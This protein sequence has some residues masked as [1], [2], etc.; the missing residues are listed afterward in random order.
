MRYR[1]CAKPDAVASRLWAQ[2]DGCSACCASSDEGTASALMPESRRARLN[3]GGLGHSER[4]PIAE[5]RLH[6][7]SSCVDCS[8]VIQY[9]PYSWLT[10]NVFQGAFRRRLH[11]NRFS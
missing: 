8:R 4:P 6:Q 11:P 3:V 2:V 5:D 9:Q 1:A 10:D 7:S